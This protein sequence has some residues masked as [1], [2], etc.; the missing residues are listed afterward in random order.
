MTDEVILPVVLIMCNSTLMLRPA[1]GLNVE[2]AADQPEQ[3]TACLSLE[4]AAQE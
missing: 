3:I 2:L 4:A 1:N